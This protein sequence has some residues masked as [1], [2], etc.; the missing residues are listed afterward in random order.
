MIDTTS[1]T[2]S[3]SIDAM[4]LVFRHLFKVSPSTT[5]QQNRCN[6][7]SMPSQ[8][9][10]CIFDRRSY[11]TKENTLSFAHVQSEF[12]SLYKKT[13]TPTSGSKLNHHLNTFSF[14]LCTSS[15]TR[16]AINFKMKATFFFAILALLIASSQASSC[17]CVCYA[18]H[19]RRSAIRECH[20]SIYSSCTV[21]ACS[22]HHRNGLKCC[23]PAPSVTPSTTPSMSMPPSPSPTASMTASPSYSSTPSPSMS[24]APSASMTPSSSPSMSAVPS[25]TPVCPCV[26]RRGAFGKRKARHECR[27]VRPYCRVSR[28]GYRQFQ[29]CH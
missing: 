2:S 25:P 26:C 14:S 21:S 15:P 19:H 27:H 28:C 13:R 7:N 22:K 29:C 10:Q 18:A 1:A 24:A 4:H 8:K 9:K 12:W 3:L 11:F 23:D 20:R 16:R 5:Q 17:P 6:E